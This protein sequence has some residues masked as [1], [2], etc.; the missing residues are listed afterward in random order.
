M[1]AN[2]TATEVPFKKELS[3]RASAIDTLPHDVPCTVLDAKLRSV[4]QG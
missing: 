2:S 4:E 1:E 3:I